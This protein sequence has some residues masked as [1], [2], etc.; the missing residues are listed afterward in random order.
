[1]MIPLV[2]VISTPAKKARETGF[3]QIVQ[4]IL[5]AF[6][7]S[8][9]LPEL[10]SD[11]AKITVDQ[12]V[13]HLAY[14]YEKLRNVIDFK[15][16]KLLR[17]N[18]LE[19]VLKRRLGMGGTAENISLSLIKELI[20]AGYIEN[21]TVPEMKIGEIRAIIDKY[22]RLA[23]LV[24]K[25][26]PKLEQKEIFQWFFGMAA[27]EIDQLL[28]YQG[29]DDSLMAAMEEVVKK[30]VVLER[31]KMSEE[32]R[33]LQFFLAIRRTFVR[34]DEAMI[35]YDLW[36]RS[37][38]EWKEPTGDLLEEFAGH[39]DEIYNRF[40]TEKNHPLAEKL[41]AVMKRYSVL[42]QILE[43]VIRDDPGSAA[44]VMRDPEVFEEKIRAACDERYS[45]TKKK[46][47]RSAVRAI[48][49]IFIT[50]MLL[51]IILEFPIDMYIL[52][53]TNI[54][55]IIINSLF[56]PVFMF[57][58]IL[59]IRAPGDNNTDRIVNG[60]KMIVYEGGN[61]KSPNRIRADARRGRLSL[62][63]FSVFYLAL[64]FLSF[65]SIIYA[66]D[67]WLDFSFVSIIIFLF[68]LS[69]ITFFAIRLRQNAAEL[70]IIKKRQGVTG[71]IVDIF[72]IPL[73]RVGYWFSKKLPKINVFIF[74]FDVILEA[75]F[76]AFIEIFEDW[77]GFL[78]EKKE[79]VY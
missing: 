79:E 36:M 4:P 60:L 78:K 45:S 7:Y 26:K 54:T 27:V 18:A 67:R 37:F 47:R 58:V 49:Y 57:I 17:K 42:F 35:N 6:E 73:V 72:A 24:Y 11:K 38:P 77:I 55:P 53:H 15:E 25:K 66:L 14:I 16:E 46:L 64:Y 30:S 41:K 8:G 22:V 68:F 21:N 23:N 10:F 29:I 62:A 5:D 65:G 48:L 52:R 74:I 50:K 71:F 12:V 75:P 63:L 44:Q 59:W 61:T 3:D 19:R 32:D 9:K 33:S 13:S 40:E 69:T 56:H 2:P 31:I 1:M 51:G 70:L 43:D 20:R 39:I 34:S 76:K 28:V